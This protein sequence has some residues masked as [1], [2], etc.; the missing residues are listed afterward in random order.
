MWRSC[1]LISL[2]DLDC[3]RTLSCLA[4]VEYDAWEI[5]PDRTVSRAEQ[6]S[7][8]LGCALER[9]T[10]FRDGRG[11]GGAAIWIWGEIRHDGY[12]HSWTDPARAGGRKRRMVI[13]PKARN[14]PAAL[15][16]SV[17]AGEPG[18]RLGPPMSVSRPARLRASGEWEVGALQLGLGRVWRG[19]FRRGVSRGGGT[20]RGDDGGDGRGGGRCR[21]RRA[22]W[23]G[24]LALAL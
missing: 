14:E 5:G 15:A 23:P 4:F 16:C 17:G 7:V 21:G 24:D 8:G 12:C 1:V 2:R 20:G 18:A 6:C 10:E 9:G 3:S 11:E 22:A 19:E 13:C